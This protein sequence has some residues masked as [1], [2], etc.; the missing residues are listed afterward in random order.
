MRRS[1]VTER[2]PAGPLDPPPGPAARGRPRRRRLGWA[3]AA[4]ALLAVVLGGWYQVHQEM[5]AWYARL[6]YP[7][8]YE[9]AIVAEAERRGLDPALVAAVVNAE[10]GFLPDSRSSQ[11]AVGLMQMLPETA[12]FVAGLP[13]R[14][15]PSPD[16]LEDPAVNIAYG[17][18]YLRYLVERHGTVPLALAAYNGGE[19]NVAAWLEDADVRGESLDIPHDIPFTETRTFVT[20]V[21]DTAPVYRRAYD[22]R[23]DAPPV[24]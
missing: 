8:E 18:R 19:T 14:P 23:L 22:D 3:V 2:P 6:W 1:T 15:S 20:R 11:G 12:R 5:P 24:P 4:L 21:L 13:N 9:E 17:T 7:L 10:S 16:R